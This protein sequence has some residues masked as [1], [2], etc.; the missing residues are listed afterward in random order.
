M[1]KYQISSGRYRTLINLEKI[2]TLMKK[3]ASILLGIVSFAHG[4]V[5]IKRNLAS[6][7]VCP[8]ESVFAAGSNTFVNSLS[9]NVEN[10]AYL[11]SFVAPLDSTL[12]SL[13]FSMDKPSTNV[14]VRLDVY[15]NTTPQINVVNGIASPVASVSIM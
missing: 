2:K 13:S 3:L 7:L 5:L 6:G 4:S 10:D 1:I 12:C 9:L 8:G 15:D 14:S 11:Q